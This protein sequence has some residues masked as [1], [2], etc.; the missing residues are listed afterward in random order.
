M[1]TAV[2]HLTLANGLQVT[3]RH[4]AHLKRSAAALRVHAGSHDAPRAWPG[5]AHFLEH[6]LFLGTD[7][8][9]LDDGLMRHVQRQG[10]QVNAS[11]RER[12]TDF[13]CEVPTPAFAGA[14]ERLCDMLAHPRFDHER[15]LR[16]REVLHA[17]FI[18]WSRNRQ[19]QRLHTLLQSAQDGHP[20][21]AF[22]AG[23][24]FSLPVHSAAFQQALRRFHQQF[25]QGGQ[26]TLSLV[27][28]QSLAALEALAQQ[29][30]AMLPGGEKIIPARPPKLTAQAPAQSTR[31]LDVLFA[32]EHL[33]EG[34]EAAI[35][36]LGTWMAD[37]RPGGLLAK[38]RQRGWLDDFHF[39]PLYQHAGQALLQV[40]FGLSA[41]ALADEVNRLLRDWLRFLSKADLQGLNQ[42]YAAI[43][44]CREQAASALELARQDSSGQPFQAL[45]TNALNAFACLLDSSLGG[46]RQ[47]ANAWKL[48]DPEPLLGVA[49]RPATHCPLPA[50]LTLSTALPSKRSHGV[51]Y[52][53]WHS[54]SC[55]R[56]RLWKVLE[57]A[58]RP[59][60]ERASRAA[61]TLEFSA[62]QGFWQMRCAGNPAAVVAVVEEALTHLQAPAP[63]SW[64]AGADTAEP[65]IPIRALLQQLPQVIAGR[66][67]GPLPSCILTPDDLRALWQHATWQGMASG[68]ASADQHNLNAVLAQIPG[69]PGMHPPTQLDNTLRWEQAAPADSESAVLLFY[70]IPAHSEAAWRLLAQL[71]QG[72]FYQRLRVELQLGYAVFSAVRQ[73]QGCTGLVLGVQSPGASQAEIIDH[74]VQFL[75]AFAAGCT[76]DEAARLALASQFDETLMSNTDVAEWAWQAQ[77]AGRPEATLEAMKAAMLNVTEAQLERALQHL[78][79]SELGVLCLANSPAPDSGWPLEPRSARVD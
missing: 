55:L 20:L 61:V 67:D 8:F 14:L 64:Q 12:T 30:G 60:A 5:L 23:N 65:L 1:P 66:H 74:I 72:P 73:V 15:Q 27:G 3:L 4:A 29:F 17:E 52:L 76:L 21:S 53:R 24:R 44:Q 58:L 46:G 43:Q 48:P 41:T 26:M 49:S 50:G 51:L 32:C 62:C 19:A 16:E 7:A 33:P 75:T 13:F 54:S 70:S 71:L 47:H 28:P 18:A 68:F 79:S 9:P 39:T 56:D 38:L 59:L 37:T 63:S 25:Y 22:H 78:C 77:L 36:F 2:Q 45:D 11:T 57:R 42:E 40:H 69:T 10:G 31:Q 6:L 35:A 34:Y